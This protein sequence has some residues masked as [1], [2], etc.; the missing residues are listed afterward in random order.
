MLE[1]VNPNLAICNFALMRCSTTLAR[2]DSN[3]LLMLVTLFQNLCID[4]VTIIPHNFPG[5]LFVAMS[6]Q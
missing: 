4:K 5:F 6:I 2:D 1:A 3:F